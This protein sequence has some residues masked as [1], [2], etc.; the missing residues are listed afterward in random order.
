MM[1]PAPTPHTLCRLCSL[2]REPQERPY[3]PSAVV[4]SRY[5]AWMCSQHCP[6][7]LVFQQELGRQ[8]VRV[9][10]YIVTKG[11]CQHSPG[12]T[13]QTLSQGRKHLTDGKLD[14]HS[15]RAI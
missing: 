11:T 10:V 14:T 12:P 13:V 4:V 3:A 9:Q 7:A 5:L 15:Q 2:G 8:R 6:Q 1:L